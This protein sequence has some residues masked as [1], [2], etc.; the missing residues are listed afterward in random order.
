MKYCRVFISTFCILAALS[1]FFFLVPQKS[2]A[3]PAVKSSSEKLWQQ[4]AAPLTPAEQYSG[5]L[6][7]YLMEVVL[8]R[9]G[10]PESRPPWRTRAIDEPLD[11]DRIVK[12][13]TDS[14]KNRLDFMV[15]DPNILDLSQVLYYYDER[16]SLYKGDYGVTSV[17]PAPEVL[18]LRLFLLKKIKAGEKIRLDAFMRRKAD[19]LNKNYR[20]TAED[21]AATA[22]SAKEMQFLREVFLSEPAF[23]RYLIYPFLLKELKKTDILD[24]GSLVKRIIQSANYD[25]LRCNFRDCSENKEAVRIAFFPSMTKEFIYGNRDPSLSK[26]GFKPTE[27]L[28][29]IFAK[30]KEEILDRTRQTLKKI[31]SKPPY[32]KLDEAE[33][34]KLWQQISHKYIHFYLENQRPLVIYPG[35]ASEVINEICPETDFAVILMGKNIYRAIFFDPSKDTYPSVNRLYLDIMDIEYNQAAEEIGL[36]S[37]FICSRLKNRIAVLAAQSTRQDKD[38]SHEAP[39]GFDSF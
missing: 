37:R 5:E 19:L 23:Y 3:S 21:L 7:A 29:E 28:E 36:I 11:F 4:T 26:H 27:F 2:G 9:A 32:R 18:A 39:Y 8:G 14:E 6:L 34:L 25:G 33:W 38:L 12:S 22:L 17:Y 16:L 13:M 35:N 1:L 20:P 31:L 24:A 15:L 30:L 10:Q